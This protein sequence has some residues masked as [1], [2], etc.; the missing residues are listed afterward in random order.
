MK[1]IKVELFTICQGVHDL[2]GHLTIVNTIDN[3]VVKNLP[4]RLSFGIALKL[5]IRPQTEGEHHLKI[6]II[7]HTDGKEIVAPIPS[8]LKIEKKDKASH[9]NMALN[10]QNV[11]F[12]TEGTYDIH[13]ELDGEK[14][15]NFAFDVIKDER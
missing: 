4:K 8:I 13:L 12:E 7:H 9:I 2:Y 14:L 6:S 10:L 3:F 1:K 11:I 5:Y 15:D